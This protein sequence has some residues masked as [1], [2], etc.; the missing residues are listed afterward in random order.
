M[1]LCE[2]WPMGIPV[3]TSTCL[4]RLLLVLLACPESFF[5][6]KKDSRKAEMNIDCFLSLM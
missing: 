6:F 4:R 1:P 5:I 3:L 2:P